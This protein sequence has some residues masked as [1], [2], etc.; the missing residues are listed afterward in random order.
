MTEPSKLVRCGHR[1]QFHKPLE[2]LFGA[3]GF[4]GI[5]G[6]VVIVGVE[7]PSSTGVVS[8]TTTRRHRDEGSTV[9]KEAV[10]R[11]SL[12]LDESDD[13]TRAPVFEKSLPKLGV[14]SMR[15]AAA[16][17]QQLTLIVPRGSVR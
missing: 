14:V 10:L 6:T 1:D 17:W 16:P 13:S 3:G 4:G 5:D 11:R 7:E 15:V 12:A 2:R 8:A 9:V